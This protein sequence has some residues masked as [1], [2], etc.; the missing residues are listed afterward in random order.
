[1]VTRGY[2][3]LLVVTRGY[4]WLLVVTRGHS[5]VL[6]VIALSTKTVERVTGIEP[7]WPAW[8]GGRRNEIVEASMLIKP[9][10]CRIFLHVYVVWAL[11]GH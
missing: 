4:S 3:W 6:E 5:K 9:H 8:K 10:L 7:A 11:H 2:S 1:V